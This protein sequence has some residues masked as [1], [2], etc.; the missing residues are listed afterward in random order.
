MARNSDAVDARAQAILDTWAA[1][2]SAEDSAFRQWRAVE[3][4]PETRA[5]RR[6]ACFLRDGRSAAARILD[7]GLDEG[8]QPL[9]A[10]RQIARTARKEEERSV[11]ARYVRAKASLRNA[12]RSYELEGVAMPFAASIDLQN[13]QQ[14]LD[15]AF[16][17]KRFTAE[18]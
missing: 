9:T 8:E 3:R 16:A 12:A 15:E 4:R 1:R 5:Q 10:S 17:R 2:G 14:A 11:A 18:I 7:G 6:F 13:A